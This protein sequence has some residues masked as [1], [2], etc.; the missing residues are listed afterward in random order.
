MAGVSVAVSLNRRYRSLRPQCWL[1]CRLLLGSP[2][3]AGASAVQGADGCQLKL[4]ATFRIASTAALLSTS[5]TQ[6]HSPLRA[7]R[8]YPPTDRVLDCCVAACQIALR[9]PNALQSRRHNQ[10]SISACLL[11]LDRAHHLQAHVRR[12]LRRAM[13]ALLGGLEVR[14]LRLEDVGYVLLR[15]AVDQRK[16]RALHLDHDSVALTK[17]VVAPV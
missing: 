2:R 3:T 5:Q 7:S 13:D 1:W 4:A 14:L 17:A 10:I 11:R 9:L 16:P 8:R 15:I 6:R 12:I